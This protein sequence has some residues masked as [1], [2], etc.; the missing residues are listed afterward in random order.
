MSQS[1]RYEVLDVA[2]LRVVTG[3]GGIDSKADYCDW[4]DTTDP[5]RPA[6]GTS[7][8]PPPAEGNR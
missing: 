3:G 6:F 5:I 1:K 7:L 2:S 8:C 4:Q